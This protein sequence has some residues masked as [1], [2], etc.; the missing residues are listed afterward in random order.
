MVSQVVLSRSEDGHTDLHLGPVLAGHDSPVPKG[1][2]LQLGSQ[3]L[4]RFANYAAA[5]DFVVSS[6]MLADASL[7]PLGKVEQEQISDVMVD[8]LRIYG[9]DEVEAAMRDEYDGIYVIGVNL[10]ARLSGMRIS[11]RR[12]GFVETSIVEEAERLL[13]SAWRELRLS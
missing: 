3:D 13:D 2:E 4:I 8:A 7:V 10:V 12:R 6:F 5:H 9:G 1:E 11:I